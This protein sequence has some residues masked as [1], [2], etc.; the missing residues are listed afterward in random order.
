MNIFILESR[1]TGNVDAKWEADFN[2][3]PRR[4]PA[5]F[6]AGWTKTESFSRFEFRIVEYAPKEP[7]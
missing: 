6:P 7:K 2:T 1:P 3:V 4:S 5:E